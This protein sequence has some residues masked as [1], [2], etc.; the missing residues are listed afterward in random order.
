MEWLFIHCDHRNIYQAPSDRAIG[1][2][3]LQ[4]SLISLCL[5]QSIFLSTYSRF[6]FCNLRR[7]CPQT[8]FCQ[9]FFIPYSMAIII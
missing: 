1:F 5:V 7:S 9:V 6:E 8:L 2:P 4:S 3:S